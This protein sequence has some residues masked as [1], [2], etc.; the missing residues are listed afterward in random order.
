[1]VEAKE[2]FLYDSSD[3]QP[4]EELS[5]R[6]PGELGIPAL[7]IRADGS[8]DL[9]H[10]MYLFKGLRDQGDR[11]S[12]S[13]SKSEPGHVE[14]VRGR[15]T[16][17]SSD[18]DLRF[19]GSAKKI[20]DSMSFR[21]NVQRDGFLSYCHAVSI[22]EY[23]YVVTAKL[24]RFVGKL[25]WDVEEEPFNTN[26]AGQIRYMAG[27]QG[28]VTCVAY[29][30]DGRF[31]LSGG[32]DK[33]IRLWDTETGDEVKQ[34][35]GHRCS[36]RVLAFSP[37]GRLIISGSALKSTGDEPDSYYV[38]LW[39]V[40][41]GREICGFDPCKSITSV[42][43]SPDGRF[44]VAGG[45]G[46]RGLIKEK[47]DN[48][49][50][51][52]VETGNMI[53]SLAHRS[54]IKALAFSPNS[55]FLVCVT[56]THANHY[57]AISLWDIERGRELRQ[58]GK[59]LSSDVQSVNFSPDG[60]RILTAD[61]YGDLQEWNVAT[62]DEVRRFDIGSSASWQAIYSSDER[63]IL[64]MNRDGFIMLIDSN[65]GQIIKRFDNGDGRPHGI[66]FSPDG[67]RAV[68]ATVNGVIRLWGISD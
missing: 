67:R 62:G 40:E 37:N 35:I 7:V 32:S 50:V 43:F 4:E 34:F 60:T 51:W 68:S 2:T 56:S 31:V 27:H 14:V 65:T 42:A 66:A 63:H 15:Y 59:G 28:Y 54:F 10:S 21:A 30:P 26:P 38:R 3:P 22:G 52:E 46:N 16:L 33:I 57:N 6:K 39:E 48:A 41:S 19:H 1:M 55:R 18:M 23:R 44:V 12:I 9:T 36:I 47:W 5:R 20:A 53:N 45:Y 25:P 24:D 13:T 58:F 11:Y 17:N 61:P 49:W 64:S 29:S 8:F